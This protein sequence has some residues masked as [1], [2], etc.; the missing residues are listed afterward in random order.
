MDAQKV[1]ALTNATKKSFESFVGLRSFLIMGDIMFHLLTKLYNNVEK[2]L[3]NPILDPY[4]PEEFLVIRPTSKIKIN[5]GKF[6]IELLKTLILAY[7]SYQI[8]IYTEPYFKRFL[9]GG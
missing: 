6:L 3:L 4:V 9:K 5:L 7:M 1:K 2:N 8:F